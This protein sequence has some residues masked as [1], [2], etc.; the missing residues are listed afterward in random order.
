MSYAAVMS[1]LLHYRRRTALE[2]VHAEF[3]KRIADDPADR[4]HRGV[5]ADWLDDHDSA[6]DDA[7]LR[8]LREEP[9]PTVFATADDGRV[10]ARRPFTPAEMQ[11]EV[12]G[13]DW[14][15]LPGRQGFIRREVREVHHGPGGIYFVA[16][17]SE[18]PHRRPYL[19]VHRYDPTTG[20]IRFHD[21]FGF[22]HDADARQ[23]AREAAN[24]RRGRSRG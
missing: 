19:A 16:T 8:H 21:R 23:S 13:Y 5:Y 6:V 1:Q 15:A 10:W 22:H 3:Q 24:P 11:A 2:P 20:E 4:N 18:P 14:Y 12:D 17:E 9:G 7:T